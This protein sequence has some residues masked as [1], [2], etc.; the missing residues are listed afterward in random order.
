MKVA[1]QGCCHGD[2]DAIY[3]Y[4]EQQER[5][6]GYKVDLL[7]ICGDFQAMRNWED[8]T[9]M[10]CPDKYKEIKDFHR[11]YSG[12]REAPIL[13][14]VIGGNHEASSY[15]WELYHGG[16]L[17]PN[18]Y[19]LGNAG[20]V[21]VNGLRISGS[22]GIYNE[23]HF[24]LGHYEKLPYDRSTMRSI[25]HTREYGIRKLSLLPQPDIFISHDWPSSI[26][27]YGDLRGLLRHK[28]YLKPDIEARTLGSPPLMGLLKTL[29]PK[30]WF[31][32]HHHIRFEATVPHDNPIMPEAKDPAPTITNPDEIRIDDDEAADN[33]A[34]ENISSVSKSNP[35]E[36]TLSDEE[37]DVA[38][39]SQSPHL[40]SSV[41]K[42]LALDKCLPRRTFLE[43]LDIPSP[44][45]EPPTLSFDPVW[46]AIL[47]AFHPNLSLSR[48]QA[49]FPKEADAR[50]LV[51]RELQWVNENV[52][53]KLDGGWAVAD[54]QKFVQTASPIASTE[55]GRMK[56]GI[57]QPSAYT[58]PQTEALCKMLNIQN[59]IAPQVPL[60]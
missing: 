18:I 52:P 47:R 14:I 16:W 19:F 40:G 41:T 11:Y 10:A 23:S 33:I 51:A 12:A 53:A 49:S 15:L 32:A 6:N 24:R 43:V 7:L 45:L 37:Q 44:S 26:E 60:V 17:A 39:P 22:S 8:L 1:V 46:L 3:S 35:D 57:T 29:R 38:A 21:I 36:I 50:A 20:S 55:S 54:C 25:Y 4:V 30:W 48:M 13:T 31:A 58:N 27:H 34:N 56:A 42:F 28:P 2:L 59:K 5:K 9:T